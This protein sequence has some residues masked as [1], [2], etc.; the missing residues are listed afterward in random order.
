MKSF[1]PIHNT[2]NIFNTYILLNNYMEE[3]E[4]SWLTF[5]VKYI[6]FQFMLFNVVTLKL[7]GLSILYL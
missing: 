4:N 7:K 6:Y 1:V 2:F 3:T 5:Y